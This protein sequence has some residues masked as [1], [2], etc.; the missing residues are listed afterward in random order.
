MNKKLVSIVEV[1][2]VLSMLVLT[3][4]LAYEQGEYDGMDS[5]CDGDLV[6]FNGVIEC[7]FS[8]SSNVKNLSFGGV[9]FD[10]I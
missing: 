2:V 9:V 7:S 5:M 6:E 10:K 4:F 1:V 8:S 3:A